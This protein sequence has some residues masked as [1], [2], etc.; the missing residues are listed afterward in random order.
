MLKSLNRIRNRNLDN[1][2][3]I[4]PS[5]NISNN[6]YDLDNFNVETI[7]AIFFDELT[8]FLVSAY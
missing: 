6:I 2:D 4:Y 1:Y 5:N 8:P 3:K 7:R